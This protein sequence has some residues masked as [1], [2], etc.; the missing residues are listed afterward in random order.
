MMPG[1]L[2]G[3]KDASGKKVDIA[4]IDYGSVITQT[5]GLAD[6]KI[7]QMIPR[8]YS[9][10][11]FGYD[12]ARVNPECLGVGIDAP[13]IQRTWENLEKQGFPLDELIT[14]LVLLDIIQIL[15]G[16]PASTPGYVHR[17]YS[18]TPSFSPLVEMVGYIG[19]IWTYPPEYHIGLDNRLGELR[20]N[21]KGIFRSNNLGK[22]SQ[23]D[24]LKAVN[25]AGI[26]ILSKE[27]EFNVVKHLLGIDFK[28]EFL[29]SGTKPTPDLTIT[30]KTGNL[31]CE[32]KSRIVENVFQNIVNE[33]QT[34]GLIG[35]DPLSLPPESIFALLSWA[36]FSTIKR[37]MD[38][39]KSQILFCDLSRTFIGLMFPALESFWKINLN[40][41]EATEH[42]CT[43]A[44]NGEQVIIAF[45]SLPGI[46]HHF[47]ATVFKRSDIEPTGKALWDLN[48]ELSLQSPQ[49]AK[50]L[51]EIFKTE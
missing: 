3:G 40:F 34:R 43:L 33:G 8:A 46:T 4:Y 7:T 48:K 42:A 22:A 23:V 39:Q 11:M 31:S 17:F 26:S 29:K 16:I 44:N 5:G 36:T 30:K 27:S 37:A 14:G 41:S 20:K 1:I 35:P 21:L 19:E 18:T 2:I 6:V 12:F 45:V 25:Q 24:Y 49:L 15:R 51:S 9:D 38:E 47:K 50:F 10:G 13:A 32:V 28:C